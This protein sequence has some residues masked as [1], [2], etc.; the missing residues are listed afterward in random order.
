MLTERLSEA[1]SIP[2]MSMWAVVL[3]KQ[4]VHH[5]LIG[6]LAIGGDCLA[7]YWTTLS[8]PCWAKIIINLSKEGEIELMK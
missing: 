8:E 3:W 5:Q 4:G 6:E 7:N 2:I 1:L